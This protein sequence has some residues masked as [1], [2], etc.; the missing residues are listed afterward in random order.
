MRNSVWGE[1]D[2][3]HPHGD[4]EEAAGPEMRGEVWLVISV[5]H[6]QD[7]GGISSPE[8]QEFFKGMSI[9]REQSGST[10]ES[11]GPSSVRDLGVE[12]TGNPSR[13]GCPEC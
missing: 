6:L 3:K 9:N 1:L 7:E 13:A 12:A 4:M 11:W 8:L 10:A 5:W 2:I